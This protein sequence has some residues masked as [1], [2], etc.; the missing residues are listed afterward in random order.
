MRWFLDG[1]GYLMNA[2]AWIPFLPRSEAFIL[3]ACWS[4][5]IYADGESGEVEFRE[6]MKFINAVDRDGVAG[7]MASS[8]F[9]SGFSSRFLVL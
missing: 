6:Y 7:L 5:D 4:L 8:A 1:K 9:F 3:Y 2:V